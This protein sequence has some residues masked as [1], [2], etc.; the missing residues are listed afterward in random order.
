MS[1]VWFA[2][3]CIGNQIKVQHNRA[4]VEPAVAEERPR[5]SL[6]MLQANLGWVQVIATDLGEGDLLFLTVSPL[7]SITRSWWP[8]RS[9]LAGR[10]LWLYTRNCLVGL[11]D[12][13]GYWIVWLAPC[14]KNRLLW[15]FSLFPIQNGH[16]ITIK[17]SPYDYSLI[18]YCDYFPTSP[19]WFQVKFHFQ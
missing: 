17:L 14:E 15:L 11:Q 19:S 18:G 4:M 8:M 6:K 2:F 10:S 3:A 1:N 7:I 13:S 16:F 9:Y 5:P 12:Y